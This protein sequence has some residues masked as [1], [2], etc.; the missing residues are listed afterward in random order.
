MRRMYDENEIKSI[1]SEA[2]GGKYYQH[3]IVS[4]TSG[5]IEILY[6]NLIN[7]STTP[8]TVETINNENIKGFVNGVVENDR[9][10]TYC[11]ITNID[12]INGKLNVNYIGANF[13]FNQKEFTLSDFGSTPFDTVTEL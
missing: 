8:L 1:A 4:A 7:S 6:I 10:S 3:R 9:D 13:S 5:D 12:F 2:G 11:P